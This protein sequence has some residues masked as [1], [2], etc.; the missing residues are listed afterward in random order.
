MKWCVAKVK[1]KDIRGRSRMYIQS[2]LDEFMWNKLDRKTA[3]MKYLK[4]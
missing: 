4:L 1:C 3:M 2:Y